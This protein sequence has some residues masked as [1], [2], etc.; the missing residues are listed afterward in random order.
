VS[1]SH[2]PR[3]FLSPTRRASAR[4]ATSARQQSRAV[5]RA[6]PPGSAWRKLAFR[7]GTLTPARRLGAD[8]SRSLSG[9]IGPAVAI[10]TSGSTGTESTRRLAPGEFRPREARHAPQVGA[11][12]HT[13]QNRPAR[14]PRP[15][16]HRTDERSRLA[17]HPR[18]QPPRTDRRS[19]L[20]PTSVS[21][22]HRPA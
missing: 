4:A 22:S 6:A 19:A 2:R 10:R 8:S 18:A 7:L 1:S 15:P 17:P 20:A 21:S 11:P 16:T 9:A 13:A 14:R 3:Q 5:C 12:R